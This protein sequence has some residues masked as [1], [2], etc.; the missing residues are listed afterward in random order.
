[1]VLLYPKIIAKFGPQI[2]SKQEYF[3]GHTK[4]DASV[5]KSLF[6]FL[7]IVLPHNV[8]KMIPGKPG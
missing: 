3:L 4:S 5:K 8:L 6:L 1:M 7:G 2:K